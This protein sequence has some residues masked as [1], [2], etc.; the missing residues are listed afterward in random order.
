M[1][2][3]SEPLKGHHD[4]E[5]TCREDCVHVHP[6]LNGTSILRIRFP[7][8]ARC[9]DFYRSLYTLLEESNR[10]DLLPLASEADFRERQD[11]L[12]VWLTHCI[13]FRKKYGTDLVTDELRLAWNAC[14]SVLGISVT[15]WPKR[16]SSSNKHPASLPVRIGSSSS[17]A[18]AVI[19]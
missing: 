13:A 11:S 6:F 19:I 2:F 8:A 1:D 10:I 5:G 7:D 12:R 18:D 16:A 4:V 3:V 14:E 17:S 9:R 15:T